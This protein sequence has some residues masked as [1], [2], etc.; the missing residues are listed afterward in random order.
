MIPY[1]Q[2]WNKVI[3]YLQK[4]MKNKF[5]RN[6][7]ICKDTWNSLNFITRNLHIIAKGKVIIPIFGNY[8]LKK[9]TLPFV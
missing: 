7:T 6:G 1:V 4:K 3:K 5:P 8:C 9:K 2:C